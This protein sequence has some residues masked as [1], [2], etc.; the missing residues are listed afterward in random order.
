MLKGLPYYGGKSPERKLCHWISSLIPDT[1]YKTYTE[2][3]AGMLG[4]LLSRPPAQTEVVNDIDGWLV[5]WWEAIRDHPEAFAH[6]IRCTPFSRRLFEECVRSK[7]EGLSGDILNDAWVA[8]VILNQ[9]LTHGMNTTK[10]KWAARYEPSR[11]KRVWYGTEIEPLANRLKHVVIENRSA[12]EILD[13]M[14]DIPDA[15]I[16]ADPPYHTANTSP[17]GKIETDWDLMTELLVSQSG[18]VAIS[19][20]SDEW[21]MTGF[22][23]S[24]HKTY[25]RSIGKNAKMKD[26]PRTEVLWTNY[27]PITQT[28][29]FTP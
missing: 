17:Y 29:L 11:D 28:E 5:A 20:Y 13:R 2:P 23:R 8:Y 9:G 4:V 24:E 19:G 12:L 21:D 14:K 25:F 27:Q 18:M 1:K 22:V 7:N 16:Y 15:V 6:K 3:F 10:E 26:A